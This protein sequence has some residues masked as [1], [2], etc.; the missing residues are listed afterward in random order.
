MDPYPHQ[1]IGRY[2]PIIVE[3]SSGG[4]VLTGGDQNPLPPQQLYARHR[5]TRIFLRLLWILPSLCLLLGL[6]LGGCYALWWS[7]ATIH[8][9]P[10]S[11][12]R[13]DSLTIM[14]VLRPQDPTQS[15]LHLLTAT[16]SSP[17]ISVQPTGRVHLPATL[18]GGTLSW[19]NQEPY[20]QTVAAGTVLTSSTGVQIVTAAPVVIG[21]SALPSSGAATGMAYAKQ[22][23]AN[24]NIPAGSVDFL[25]GSCGPGIS[26][27]NNASPFT[28]GR[29]ATTLAVLSQGD[30]DQATAPLSS[31][32][33]DQARAELLRLVP[34][35][36]KSV[37]AP[38]CS[39]H[40]HANHQ[41]GE[42]LALGTAV[43]L[44]LTET[45]SL[46]VYDPS[47]AQAR[48]VALFLARVGGHF[49]SSQFSSFITVLPQ[50]PTGLSSA[51]VALPFRV[52][53]R[54]EYRIT[55]Q[56]LRA[57]QRMIAGQTRQQALQ[58]LA[59]APGVQAAFID[60]PLPLFPLPGDPRRISVV[61]LASSTRG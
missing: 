35:G 46:R 54:W 40:I 60:Q 14:A 6:A 31:Q 47:D 50:K 15:Q 1:S 57:M 19:L 24:G 11:A 13:E 53:G 7:T 36:D 33:T 51:G 4:S 2:N 29:D 34:H 39:P 49:P 25:C 44:S 5:A 9:R 10:V 42:Q 18:A 16:R 22:A 8:L 45:C 61:Q 20:Q 21:P 28:G 41:P 52:S 12:T 27:N 17:T 23:G 30:I 48:A 59:H 37:A 58:L 55:R 56:E 26:V 43:A 38:S 3:G 32:L